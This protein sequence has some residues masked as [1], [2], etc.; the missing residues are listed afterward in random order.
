[1][2]PKEKQLLPSTFTPSESTVL[3]GKG[4]AP[5]EAPGNKKLQALVSAQVYVYSQC[6]ERKVRAGIIKGIMEEIAKTCSDD[7]APFAKFYGGRWWRVDETTI[8]EN[9]SAAFRN[10]LSDKYK[11]ST[12]H[13]S[14]KRR[15]LKAIKRA[16]K[17]SRD[18][19]NS[20]SIESMDSSSSYTVA[21]LQQQPQQRPVFSSPLEPIPTTFR[22]QS[23]VQMTFDLLQDLFK[24]E[25][26]SLLPL[27][28]METNNKNEDDFHMSN[29]I[30]DQT[31][32][33]MMT[34]PS[35]LRRNSG[36]SI[37]SYSDGTASL[38]EM[39]SESEELPE[40]STSQAFTPRQ[41]ALLCMDE[42]FH[43]DESLLLDCADPNIF[44][45]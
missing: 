16:A 17:V 27:P 6:Q 19:S 29:L 45:V 20:S 37:V 44:E 31:N 1:M 30:P 26:S 35:L 39:P 25:P 18:I 24:D 42:D 41:S 10:K 43:K 40:L 38:S 12:K 32:M 8:R 7:D 11:S 28:I 33:M 14:A 15:N 36:V 9:I 4:R 3:I 22:T 34:S 23:S 2:F 5:R 13:K 21:D